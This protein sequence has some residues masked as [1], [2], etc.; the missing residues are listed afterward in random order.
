MKLVEG[1]LRRVSFWLPRR[2]REDILQ[3]LRGALH[4]KIETHEEQKGRPLRDDEIEKALRSFG[5]PVLV[6]ARYVRRR[7]VISG[8]LAFFFWRVLAITLAGILLVQLAVLIVETTRAPTI[9]AALSS[10]L[11][12]IFVAL[13]LGFTCVTASFMILEH[14]YGQG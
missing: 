11:E 10:G 5:S 4:E 8:G 1:Y 12:R 2:G 9:L 14:R 7:P 13:L 6:V 3:E